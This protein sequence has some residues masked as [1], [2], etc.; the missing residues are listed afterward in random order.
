MAMTV[1]QLIN[2]LNK[3]PKRMYVGISHHDNSEGEIAGYVLCV[4]VVDEIDMESHEK[5]GKCVVLKC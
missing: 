2:K 5:I 3:M 1:Q 4:N